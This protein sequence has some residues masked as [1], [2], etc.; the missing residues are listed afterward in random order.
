MSLWS[1]TLDAVIRC[2]SGLEE[3]ARCPEDL[4]AAAA[5]AMAARLAPGDPEPPRLSGLAIR[6]EALPDWWTE[7]G[8]LL[9]ANPATDVRLSNGLGLSPTGRN[10]CLVGASARVGHV[11]FAG[12]ADCLIAIGDGAQMPGAQVAATREG[13]VFIGDGVTAM[14]FA[15]VDGRNGGLVVVG[16]DG[17]WGDS[18]NIVTDDMHAI[19]EVATDRR[20]NGFGGRIVI[21]PHVWI[22]EQVNVMGGARIGA[23]SV[24]EM[25]AMVR[26]APLPPNSFCEGS[27]ALPTREGLVWTREDLP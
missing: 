20:T 26:G 6:R 5:E 19:R 10:L 24:V 18:V 21:E 15:R 8:G 14:G 17:L 1:S 22:G 16:A 7:S 27:P 9:L 12:G 3:G 25:R 13:A 23:G 11:V 2:A 4:L